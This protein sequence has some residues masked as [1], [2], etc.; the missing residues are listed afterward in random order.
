MKG[1]DARFRVANLFIGILFCHSHKNVNININ[2]VLQHN[3][4][5]EYVMSTLEWL[6]LKENKQIMFV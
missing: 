4:N 6:V 5:C 2:R 3:I 1:K